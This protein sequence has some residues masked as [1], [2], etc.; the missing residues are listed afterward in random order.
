[1][2][3][4]VRRLWMV[5]LACCVAGLVVSPVVALGEGS[6]PEGSPS[7]GGTGA[8]SLTEGSLVTS[9]S[10]AEGEQLQAQEQAKL[11]S[12]E[13]VA[14][15][16][17]SRSEFEGLAGAGAVSLAEQKFGIQTP[18]W[19]PPGDQEGNHITSYL[20]TNRLQETSSTG[21]HLLLQSSVALRSAVGS[22]Q[23]EPTSYSLR[24]ESG[25]Y[26]PANPVVPV[27][28]SKTPSGGVSLPPGIS[29][30]PTQA[31]T[32]EAPLVVGDTV[33][34]P[35][36]AMDTD[37]MVE[38]IPAGVSVSWQLLSEQ[39][40]QT[41]GL[42]FNLP[43]GASLQLSKTADGA[44]EVVEEGEVLA[45][46]PRAAARE[47]NGSV[48]PVTYTVSGDTLM[49]HVDLEGSVDFPVFIDPTVA[50]A[51]GSIDGAGNW[52]PWLSYS[53]CGCFQFP[54]S[55]DQLFVGQ[56]PELAV[57]DYGEWYVD[58]PNQR[59]AGGVGIT[60]VDVTG[61]G[62]YTANEQSSL[63]AG[64]FDSN[65]PDPDWTYN[66]EHGPV[67]P[68]P[69]ITEA[70]ES[71]MSAAFC[72]QG[73]PGY[74]GGNPEDPLCDPSNAGEGFDFLDDVG[75]ARATDFTDAEIGG[76]RVTYVDY[77]KPRGVALIGLESIK[78]LRYGPS[79]DYVSAVDE[80]VGI[81]SLS[82]EIPPGYLNEHGQPFFADSS[83]CP[84]IGFVGCPEHFESG[85][86]NFSELATGVYSLGVYGYD[87]AGNVREEEVN[88]SN[89]EEDQ[90]T[91]VD[92]KLYIDHTAPTFTAFGGSLNEANGGVIGSGNYTLNFGAV[93]GS[94]GAPQ[95][96]VR[97][98]EVYVDGKYADEVY[99]SC[100][101]PAGVPSASCF[102][103]SGSWTLEGQRYGAGPHTIT[104]TAR[105]WMGNESTSESIHVTVNE[106]PYESLGPGAVNLK[107]GD[108][109]LNA[110]DVSIAGAAG[111]LTLNRSYD[112]R[113]LSQGA[114][115]PLGPQW[116]LSLPDSAADGEWQSMQVLPNGSVQIT[117][118]TGNKVIFVPSGSNYTSPAGYQTL[119]LTKASA[120]E[121]RLTDESGDATIFTKAGTE[122]YAP[123][124]VPSGV[125]QASSAGGLNAMTYLFA[126]TAEGIIE[127]TGMLAP[128]PSSL[129]CSEKLTKK[130]ELVAGCRALEFFYAGATK[131]K[132]G[133]D[134]TQWGEYKGRLKEV[135]F[136]A[137]EPIA[138]KMAA[139]ITV[140]E[141]AYDNLGRL[142]AEWNPQLSTPLKTI[143]GY[144]SEGHVTAVTS[145]GQQ[146]WVFTYGTTAS[147]SSTGRLLKV[148][149][150][151]VSTGA[152][153]GSP[154]AKSV[155]PKLTGS[156]VVGN[157]MSVSEGTW[158]GA[159]VAHEYRWT[160]CTGS[161][162][163]AIAGANNQSYTPVTADVG[164]T[165]V[166]EVTA[167]NS[168]G[169]ATSPSEASATVVSKVGA[170]TQSV[171][172]GNSLNAVSCIPSTT[173]CIL[174]DSKGKAFY[175]TN[176]SSSANATWNSWSG[177]SGESP[178]QAVDCPASSLCLLADGKETA[179]GKLYY[180]TSLGGSWSEAYSPSYGVDAI[181]C[182]SSSFCVDGQDGYG[183][184]RYSTS[185]ASTSWELEDQGSASMNGVFCL[186]TSFCAIA[187]SV[188]DIHIADSTTQVESASWTS[189]DVDG[190]SALHG[191]A[192]TST[193]SCVAV[194]GAG[195]V[196][197]LAISGSTPTATKHN[198]DGTNS[199]T[200][201]TC[202]GSTTCV[203]VDNVG[204]VFVSKNKGET[205]TKEYALSDKLTSVSCAST[206]LC[207]TVDTTGN[208]TAFNPAGGTATEGEHTSPAPGWTVDYNIPVSGTG[209]PTMTKAE[210]EKWGQKEDVPLEGTAI[211]P[212]DKPQSWPATE[213]TRATI[214]YLDSS[215]RAVNVSSPTGGISTT[216]YDKH[217]NV[218]RALTA[219]NRALA[220]KEAKT[221][222]A[223]EKL[224]T[225]GTY[226]TEGTELESTLGPEH[227]IKLQG[228]TE[229]IKAR[230][231][232]KYT[233]NEE[234]APSGG[235][236]RVVTKTV[237]A[238]KLANGEEKEPRT[239]A[240][241]Y[242]GQ[243]G[244]GWKLHTPT[245][246]TINPG[247]L[248]L[249]H[250]SVFSAT[251]GMVTETRMPSTSGTGNQGAHDSE[252]A[253]Y[254]PSTEASVAICQNHPQWTNLPCETQP[255]HQPEVSGMP[256]VPMTTFTYNIWDEPETT[257]STSGS[258]TR[259]ETDKYD[260]AARPS[261]KEISSSTG[262][263]LPAVNYKYNA[264]NGSLEKQRTGSG[265]EE[266]AIVSEYNALGQLASYTDAEGNTATYEYE[267]ENDARLTKVTDVK[268]SQT[269]AYNT[270]TGTIKELT[271]STAGKFAATYDSEGDIVS[272]EL[273]N[274]MSATATLNQ[275][276][277]A[278]GLVYK[279][280][281][282]C[283][284][285]EKEKCKWFTDAVVPSIHGQW[286]SQKSSL[287][288]DNYSYDETGRLTQVQDTPTG[289][290]C[291]TRSYGYDAD[292]NRT[293]LKR[294]P[295]ISGKCS[296]EGGETEIHTYDT[297]DRLIDTGT[298][299]NP[300]DDILTLPAADAGG[301]KL[302]STY[303]ADGQLASQE[304]G[305]QSIGYQLD[306]ARRTRETIATGKVTKN[307]V[308][309][310]DGPGSTPSWMSYPPSSEW[311]RDISGISGGLDAVQYNTETP[312]IQIANLHGDIVGEV[313][314]SET[315]TGL[316]TS[317][318]TTEYGVPTTSEPLKYAWLGAGEFPTELPSGV[319]NVGARSYV[320]Q[321]GRFLQ[322]DPQPG[323]SADAYAYTDG[324]P[325]N[326]SDPSGEWSLNET[327]GGL[328][329]VGTGEGT[330]LAG[331][332][333]IAAGAVEPPPVNAAA[334]AAFEAD[335]PWDQ[336]TAGSEEM[337]GYA[338]PEE[339]EEYEEG[340]EEGY[341]YAAYHHGAESGEEE[342]HIESGVLYQP[343]GGEASSEGAMHSGSTTPLC[344][345]VAE[346]PCARL[347]PDDHSRR[348]ESEC[349]RTGQ[350]C[351]GHRGGGRR[352]GG[353]SGC[354]GDEIVTYLG[355]TVI[356]IVAP[357]TIPLVIGVGGVVN[358]KCD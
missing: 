248:N 140:A 314:D 253:Y 322:P 288:A 168:G 333:G 240:D 271:D 120:S 5:W 36:T 347:V 293:T 147:D 125:V 22:G 116:A 139:P 54:A 61:L 78:W 143:Y 17:L 132:I 77:T 155:A 275:V 269:Y 19:T 223:A 72:A 62:H 134:E 243:E 37:Y 311:T 165:L 353:K 300:F 198:I 112:S 209:L 221:A 136:V 92:P 186:S 126:K 355:G 195:N 202:T 24:E 260:E 279:K 200:A 194:D 63:Q 1:M 97:S 177:P 173:G 301:T 69:L 73:G 7:A 107:T 230:K 80:G 33:V 149:R 287:S 180:A 220:L 315:A 290:E 9:G 282:N 174:S 189:T 76:A 225:K 216:E 192:C 262:S 204:N 129:K 286:I 127:P 251:S 138:K 122:E 88:P 146:P 185:P 244:L 104:V 71:D 352:G 304:Q 228:A 283:T 108:Y 160:R 181:S 48:L 39:S 95:S 318:D 162:C 341:E 79:N 159:P 28:I 247:G 206:T 252:V 45:M 197:Y 237:E 235:P 345:A 255:V 141:Y 308:D 41:N 187:D 47:A 40:S 270:T 338:E 344:E 273:P 119:I 188:G 101:E 158:S 285:E 58:A 123:M 303:Y 74:D 298:T 239:I 131:E 163:V 35:G 144:D 145:P 128:Y 348:V 339:E 10:P 96:G 309:H 148:M 205:W 313:L 15:R 190:T 217:N 172:S 324:D 68:S 299:Y 50:G 267:K 211:F 100:P 294:T 49:T 85:A 114:V 30:A 241:S 281:T 215:E 20:G 321:L 93:D 214:Y 157:K 53:N 331:G 3:G 261:S 316:K 169:S 232:V 12:P 31:A 83:S 319:L 124:F 234:G 227:E 233:Y 193:T 203:T 57:G 52:N 257:K 111:D 106:A 91:K 43:E 153:A 236:Y 289:K 89:D 64:I 151:A 226:N 26:E 342:H 102:G 229:P 310:Y 254:T 219:D 118:A 297:A 175:A 191:V 135:K 152:W 268:G 358:L 161:S 291:A 210:V 170:L 184:F 84:E 334:E 250:T 264:V 245:S 6:S 357:E 332:V 326:E 320:P 259:T 179:G 256:E 350:H 98:L 60:R 343:L 154:P 21:Q 302:T 34:Y 218:K 207:A 242:S 212:P 113:E 349:N 263:T 336:V 87:A 296:T 99:T 208:V 224:D 2:R 317:Q 222:E 213:Y 330:Q 38:P 306:P 46:I 265:S 13:A 323:G 23:L 305:E 182:A 90:G 166:A 346:G 65:G 278:T 14:E 156:A 277:E 292:G 178:S 86:I 56:N 325:L 258:S 199:L 42:V 29:F 295:A 307:T 183:Y 164:H 133:E 231:E 18:R 137:Y 25:S 327:S 351:S 274:G 27:S 51:Y 81:Q 150:P 8:S 167:T 110:T 11:A 356:S 171:D 105:D 130:E 272:E 276:G 70:P 103:L 82:I 16:A 59:L 142:R 328:S 335:P 66:G 238:A 117:A 55:P 246:T 121:Y 196:I 312:V 266:K 201:V 249:T 340:E 109:K 176:V 44:A 67:Y 115:G 32:P 94:T 4:S 329:A 284:E 280:T 75:P 354:T 337:A